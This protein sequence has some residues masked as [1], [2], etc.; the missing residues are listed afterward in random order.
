M[1]ME[2]RTTYLA[3]VGTLGPMIGLVGTVWGM[4][5]AFRVIA[6]EGSTPRRPSSPTASP[7][8]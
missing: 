3:A 4:I 7:R 1:E 2:H 6:V 8:R 5:K